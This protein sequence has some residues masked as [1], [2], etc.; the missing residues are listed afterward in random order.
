MKYIFTIALLMIFLISFISALPQ[1][2]VQE[3]GEWKVTHTTDTDFTTW[4][5]NSSDK[6]TGG[7]LDEMDERKKNN[8]S[9]YI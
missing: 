5:D 7:F 9:I 6:K 1:P 2:T 8:E 3:V 4:I